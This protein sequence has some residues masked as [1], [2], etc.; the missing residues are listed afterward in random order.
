MVD[1]ALL[2]ISFLRKAIRAVPAV[3]W[4]VA[5]GGIMAVIAIV[6][7]FRIDARLAVVGTAIM[8]IFMSVMVVFARAS[9]LDN[10]TIARPALVFTWF[11]LLLFM[12]TTTLI[13]TS[14]FF[15]QPIDL[16]GWIAGGTGKTDAKLQVGA[17]G[18]IYVGTRIGAKWQTSKAEGIEPALTINAPGLPAPGSTYQ[19]T[20]AVHLRVAAPQ[21]RAD[22]RRPSMP[23]STGAISVG[24]SLKVDDVI[25]I[26]LDNPPR[27]WVWAHVTYVR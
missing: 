7:S 22:G 4:A 11:A 19:V 26:E 6:Q 25:Q 9:S 18:W 15:Q 27:T 3:K 2:P 8:F 10:K 21:K 24:A 5:V 13:F 14:V 12:A 23:A 17:T 16:R 1:N 20:R